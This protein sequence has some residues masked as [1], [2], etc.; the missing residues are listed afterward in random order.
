[1]IVEKVYCLKI[2]W[3][4]VLRMMVILHIFADT[5]KRNH[6]N[7]DCWLPCQM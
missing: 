6:H 3:Q 7:R 2:M 1:M 5:L 4:I